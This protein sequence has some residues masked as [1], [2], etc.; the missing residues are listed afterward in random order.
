MELG[1]ARAY[2]TAL[3]RQRAAGSSRRR[4]SSGSSSGSPRGSSG[5]SSGSSGSST[6]GSSGSSSGS[7]G[8]STGG[9][10]G[11]SSGSIGGS[12]GGFSRRRRSSGSWLP[13][14]LPGESNSGGGGVFSRSKRAAVVNDVEVQMTEIKNATGSSV[15]AELTY[16]VR[17]KG[18][19]LTA[20]VASQALNGLEHQELALE[21]NHLIV[22]KAR[23]AS[24][25]EPSAAAAGEGA[26]DERLWIIGAVLGPLAF[27]LLV[28]MLVCLLVRYRANRTDKLR[29]ETPS[30][31]STSTRHD[32]VV[33]PG[34]KYVGSSRD[35]HV[36]SASGWV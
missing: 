17:E 16:V 36:V 31:T 7:S 33:S 30:S 26:G 14:F 9:S 11:S 15:N 24:G 28:W 29:I 5:L 32:L 1:L 35:G 19:A 27:L 13:G 34:G 12:S 25:E 4:R 3:R 8:G 20:Q 6:R 23:P 10:S 21:L 22:T 18:Q 2:D